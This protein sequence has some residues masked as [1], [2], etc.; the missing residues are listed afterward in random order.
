LDTLVVGIGAELDGREDVVDDFVTHCPNVKALK[1]SESG[2]IWV[3]KFRNQ[4]DKLGVR[5]DTLV[6]MPPYIPKLKELNLDLIDPNLEIRVP[7]IPPGFWTSIG[8]NLEKLAV[9]SSDG[10]VIQVDEIQEYCRGLKSI[11]LVTL[12]G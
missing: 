12:M 1:I 3:K 11:S 7:I 4:I 9:T 6:D 5:A 8:C 2:P 10:A